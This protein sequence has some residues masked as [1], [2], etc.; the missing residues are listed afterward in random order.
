MTLDNICVIHVSGLQV[1]LLELYE[2]HAQYTE[3]DWY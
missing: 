1:M 2:Y 3:C